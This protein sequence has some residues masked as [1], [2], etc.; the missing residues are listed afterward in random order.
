MDSLRLSTK[1]RSKALLSGGFSLLLLLIS[2][3]LAG[4]KVGN[5]PLG[6]ERKVFAQEKL[7][8]TDASWTNTFPITQ[9]AKFSAIYGQDFRPKRYQFAP[10]KQ[11]F[12]NQSL[13]RQGND[14][15]CDYIA[16]SNGIQ[17][18]GGHG[19]K[20]Y[21]Q[22]RAL[23]PQKARD[24][25]ECFY[26]LLGPNGS[27]RPFTLNN[28][29]AA[30]EAFVGVYEALGYQTVHLVASPHGTD[31]NFAQ[32][33]YDRLAADPKQT[34]AHLWIT[35]SAY[36]PQAR[37]LKVAETNETVSLLYPYHEVAAIT[38]PDQPGKVIILDG[39]VGYPYAIS[40]EKLAYNLRG[41]NHVILVTRGA[42][43]LVQQQRFQLAQKGQPYVATPLGGRY[44]FAARQWWGP[45]YP[46]WGE[47]IGAPFRSGEGEKVIVPGTYVHYERIGTQ[48][49]TLALLGTQMGTDLTKG[50]I[51]QPDFIRP[52][53]EF[54]LPQAFRFWINE[55]FPSEAT[56]HHAFGKVIGAEFWL[57]QAAMEK[58]V[59]RGLPYPQV[60]ENPREGYI[61]L[62]TERAMLAWESKKGV[63]MLPLGHI[64]E[65]QLRRDLGLLPPTL[66]LRE[67]LTSTTTLLTPTL[68]LP[69]PLPALSPTLPISQ[70]QKLR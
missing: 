65:Q 2:F 34:F 38:T 4:A 15:N 66:A 39:L 51:L 46:Q 55:T 41:F 13:R 68:T 21:W 17:A 12:T 37:S 70:N 18:L 20:A 35:P 8:E 44:L 54:A 5:S 50:G 45:T 22:I 63:F 61:C 32:A 9:N 3:A 19:E 58:D 25:K 56:F 69:T 1:T 40:L 59:L 7:F 30:P 36:N 43:N 10:K 16:A 57:S 67:P 23:V 49:V 11:Q 6:S 64:Y 28:L 62:L 31:R 26:T 24:Y 14:S 33:I 42:E 47:V 48:A 52:W 27:D 29:G 60:T 53:A